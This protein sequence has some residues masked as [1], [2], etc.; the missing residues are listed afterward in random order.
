MNAAPQIS[1]VDDD[2]DVRAALDG[3]LRSAGHEARTFASAEEA[4]A[5]PQI[6]DSGCVITD[7]QMGRI[8]GLELARRLRARNR[9]I[10]ILLMTA[11]PSV[12]V[13]RRARASDLLFLGKP[14]DPNE[15]LGAVDQMLLSS[16]A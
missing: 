2:E 14:F 16:A 8:D 3:L 11:Y 15:I 1:V 4:L 10:P 6:D 7:L 9:A 13:E 5:D 12:D